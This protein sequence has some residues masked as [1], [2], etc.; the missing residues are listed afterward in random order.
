MDQQQPTPPRP[1]YE[2]PSY[3]PIEL[4]HRMI[5]AAKRKWLW[6]TPDG[7]TFYVNEERRARNATAAQGGTVYPPEITETRPALVPVASA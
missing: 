1:Q 6:V 5:W 7:A 4:Q 3:L 2:P